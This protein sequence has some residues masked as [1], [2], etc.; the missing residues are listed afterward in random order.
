MRE[1]ERQSFLIMVIRMILTQSFMNVGTI[2]WG[3]QA[4]EIR[5]MQALR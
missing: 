1:R 4:I 2:K 3:M 5:E